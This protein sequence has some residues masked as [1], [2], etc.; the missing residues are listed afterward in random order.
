MRYYFID[1]FALNYIALIKVI[2]LIIIS[3]KTLIKLPAV[4]PNTFFICG[5]KGIINS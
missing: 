5:E 4:A 1:G 3:A 2:I